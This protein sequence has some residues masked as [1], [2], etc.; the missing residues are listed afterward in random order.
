MSASNCIFA[1]AGPESKSW[2]LLQIEK[3][4]TVISTHSEPRMH[5]HGD[6]L[7]CPGMLV[8]GSSDSQTIISNHKQEVEVKAVLRHHQG[9]ITKGLVCHVCTC[10]AA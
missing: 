10:I 5:M 4:L 1:K 8:I 3:V 2:R 6:L 9:S 7:Q